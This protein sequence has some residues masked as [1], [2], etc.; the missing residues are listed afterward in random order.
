MLATSSKRN[1]FCATS[2]I[3]A[4]GKL[5][6]LQ[7]EVLQLAYSGVS[8]LTPP[9]SVPCVNCTSV[10]LRFNSRNAISLKWLV[11]NLGIAGCLWPHLASKANKPLSFG[12]PS[13]NNRESSRT[14]GSCLGLL[15]KP[16][17]QTR[18]ELSFW[19]RGYAPCVKLQGSLTLSNINSCPEGLDCFPS[20]R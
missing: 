7:A 16:P 18:V 2:F 14:E 11:N 19:L 13:G 1:W 5:T 12:L 10:S 3:T 15:R 6:T 4:V 17:L 8:C 9:Q 20:K